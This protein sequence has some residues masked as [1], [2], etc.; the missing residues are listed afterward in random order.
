MVLQHDRGIRSVPLLD[1]DPMIVMFNCF[2]VI[3]VVRVSLSI[4]R[5]SQN[6]A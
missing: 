5:E 2:K 4:Y 6:M 1:K 3:K